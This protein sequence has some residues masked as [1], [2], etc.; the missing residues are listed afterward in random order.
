MLV[1][2]RGGVLFVTPPTRYEHE[3]RSDTTEG[4]NTDWRARPSEFYISTQKK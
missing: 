3:G 2:F 1:E 4:T